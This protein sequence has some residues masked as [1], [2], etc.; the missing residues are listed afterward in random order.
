VRAALAELDRSTPQFVELAQRQV[1]RDLTH[2]IAFTKALLIYR[3]SKGHERTDVAATDVFMVRNRL[4]ALEEA[5]RQP[6]A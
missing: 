4:Q 1:K 3:E 2:V 5:P 6:R